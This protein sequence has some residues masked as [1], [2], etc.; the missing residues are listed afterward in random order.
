MTLN[1]IIEILNDASYFPDDLESKRTLGISESLIIP[2]ISEFY[3]KTGLFTASNVA[4]AIDLK[5]PITTTSGGLQ[6]IHEAFQIVSLG[7]AKMMIVVG[8]SHEITEEFLRDFSQIAKLTQKKEFP[9]FEGD[10]LVLGE[11]SGGLLLERLEHA[12]ARNA[13]IYC[14]ISDFQQIGS[15]ENFL[16]SKKVVINGD[17]VFA[18]ASGVESE[19]AYEI[20]TLKNVN[21]VTAVNPN[22]GW[23]PSANGLIES[24]F[25]ALAIQ[26]SIIPPIF[27][28]NSTKKL[29]FVKN[30]TQKEIN[31]V[32]VHNIHINGQVAC[33]NLKKYDDAQ[34][35]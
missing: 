32:S 1:S 26:K 13:K 14:E 17:L 2:D 12:I 34:N 6:A 35:P 10:G 33:L 27:S 23:I 29:N 30:L 20:E 9:L 25:G 28:E 16:N 7:E 4:S 31:T 24:V 8:A 18:N 5:G 19:D 15:K 11:G 3:L 21:N 22:I